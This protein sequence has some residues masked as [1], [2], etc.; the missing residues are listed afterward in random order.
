MYVQEFLEKD[1]QLEAGLVVEE[2]L[3]IFKVEQIKKGSLLVEMGEQQKKLPFIMHGVFRSFLI[4]EDGA[5]TT[6]G[7]IYQYGD[8]VM[9]CNEL[10]EPSCVQIE[11]LV[12]C[13]VLTIPVEDFLR[14]MEQYPVLLRPYNRHLSKA[15]HKNWEE[16]I[17]MHRYSAMQRYQWF[18]R[19]YPGLI[20]MVSNTYSASFLG[21]T[22]VTLSRLRRKLRED[23]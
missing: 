21:M 8:L 7:F 3:S 4:D 15:L 22:P 17:L 1:F 19:M 6:D 2:L 18:L 10:G 5:D 20:D 11:A 9:G 13:E 23:I 16:K 12:N 14:L